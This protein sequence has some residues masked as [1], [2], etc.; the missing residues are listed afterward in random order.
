MLPAM[1]RKAGDKNQVGRYKSRRKAVYIEEN[2]ELWP[3]KPD[4]WTGKIS[5]SDASVLVQLSFSVMGVL[6][7]NE[8]F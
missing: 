6:S 4:R 3:G 5:F 2:R 8:G 1:T 7:K